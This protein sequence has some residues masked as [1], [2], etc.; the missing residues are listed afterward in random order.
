VCNGPINLHA[1]ASA[2]PVKFLTGDTFERAVIT[3]LCTPASS[4]TECGYLY[5]LRQS[6]TA[7][8]GTRFYQSQSTAAHLRDLWPWSTLNLAFLTL[9]GSKKINPIKIQQ[10]VADDDGE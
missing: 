6:P 4:S 2:K 5:P 9:A 10:D 3:S 8:S 7:S 1:L